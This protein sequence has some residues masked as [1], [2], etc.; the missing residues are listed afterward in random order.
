M[1]YSL[2]NLALSICFARLKTFCYFCGIDTKCDTPT[3]FKYAHCVESNLKIF[4]AVIPEMSS[5]NY[6]EMITGPFSNDEFQLCK[7]LKFPVLC[8]QVKQRQTADSKQY[9]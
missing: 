2:F 6:F 5:A 3:G 7:I 8:I 9:V 4:V 1:A